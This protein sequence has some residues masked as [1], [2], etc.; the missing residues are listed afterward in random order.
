MSE[1]QR[2]K[3]SIA[4]RAYVANDPR[5]AEHRRKLAA[6]N[7]VHRRSLLP[8]EIELI[9]VMREEG[10][11]FSLIADRIGVWEEGRKAHPCENVR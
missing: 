11:P 5:W 3:L 10:Y 8:T 4:Q 2:I 7:Q 9:L 1:E 6:A